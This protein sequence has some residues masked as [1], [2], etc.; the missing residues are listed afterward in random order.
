MAVKARSEELIVKELDGELAIYDQRNHRAHELNRTAATV[1]R[2]CDGQTSVAEM[3]SAIA[4]DSDLPG[5]EGIVEIA[6]GQLAKAGL[7]DDSDGLGASSISRRQVIRR[8]G[9]AGSVALLLPAISTIVA[10]TPAM[11]ASAPPSTPPRTPS[12]PPSA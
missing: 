4:A 2:H 10:P 3:A 12:M 11:A 1:W 8:L 5:D 7:L 6:I 9:L